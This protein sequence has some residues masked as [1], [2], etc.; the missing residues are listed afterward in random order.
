M[1]RMHDRPTSAELLADIGDLLERDIVPAL[2]GP[3]QHQARVAGNLCRIVEREVRLG[4]EI[5]Q[6]EAELLSGLLG[7]EPLRAVSAADL[8]ELNQAVAERLRTGDAAFEAA[9]YPV[10]VEITKAKLSIVK[11]GHDSYDFAGENKAKAK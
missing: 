8:A 2:Q 9:A 1:R 6:H 7:R 10:L 3:I 4:P 11:P 5:D